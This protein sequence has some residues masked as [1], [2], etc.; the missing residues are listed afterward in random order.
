M[1]DEGAAL[2]RGADP[3]LKLKRYTPDSS[4]PWM[5]EKHP[6]A[7]QVPIAL[8]RYG[9]AY[10]K[11]HETDE[12]DPDASVIRAHVYN[13][14][15][16]SAILKK[17]A[18][19]W[20]RKTKAL[21][22]T[23]REITAGADKEA[24]LLKYGREYGPGLRKALSDYQYVTTTHKADGGPAGSTLGDS[25]CSSFND[26]TPDNC[27]GCTFNP[28]GAGGVEFGYGPGACLLTELF[29]NAPEQGFGRAPLT[30]YSD[31]GRP[32]TPSSYQSPNQTRRR[33]PR[34][35]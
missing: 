9:N 26:Q 7:A 34:R 30:P 29:I 8:Y 2:L 13:I 28:S 20:G 16:G 21:A 35:P 17:E 24:T 32:G 5:L 4:H 23:I 19:E 10:F 33:D 31:R 11:V 1:S 14:V 18:G 15:P 25:T 12:I 3:S 27:G 6:W 22:S